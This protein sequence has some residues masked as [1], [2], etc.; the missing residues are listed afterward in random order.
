MLTFRHFLNMVSSLKMKLLKQNALLNVKL[1]WNEPM[2]GLKAL[3]FF[4]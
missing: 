1:M 3:R 4:F 2:L